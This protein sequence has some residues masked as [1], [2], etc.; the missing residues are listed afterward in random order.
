MFCLPSI[1]QHIHKL[2]RYSVS[3][4]NVNIF[5]E[6]HIKLSK[7][8]PNFGSNG[9]NLYPISDQNIKIYTFQ[10]QNKVSKSI[11]NFTPKRFETHVPFGVARIF[12]AHARVYSLLI[13]FQGRKLSTCSLSSV[14][15]IWTKGLLIPKRME[16]WQ[17]KRSVTSAV[18]WSPP[19]IYMKLCPF[20][21]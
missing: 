9:Q 13:L 4:Q 20:V 8:L 5:T 6:F 19:L 15:I 7:F 17:P 11:P 10:F 12:W 14:L 21:Q 2:K 16:G 18:L 1:P 3:D